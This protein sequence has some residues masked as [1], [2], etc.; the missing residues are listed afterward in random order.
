[1]HRL[2]GFALF[3]CAGS[4][5]AAAPPEPGI[6][7]AKAAMSRLPL[8]FEENRGQWDPAVRF[9]A[10]SAGAN[11]Q[12][13]AHG[14]VFLVGPSRVEIGLAHASPSPVIEP[15]DRLPAATNYLVGARDQWHPGVANYARVRYQSVYPGIDVV[16]YGNQNQLEYD[17]VLAPG[18]NP[19][20]IRLNFHGDVQVSLT[21][22]GDLALTSHGAQV[23]QKAPVIYQDSRRI[24][25]RYT[26]LARNQVGF[27]LDRYHRDRP[28]IIDPIL[29]YCTYMGSS[30]ADR[31]TAIKMG[32]KGQLYITGSTNTGEMQFINGAFNNFNAGLTD[33]FLAIVDTTANGNFAIT[34]FSY[35]GGANLDTPL[36][37]EVDSNGVAYLGGS[38]TSTDF[39]VRG[40][41]VQTTGAATFVDG[42]VAVIDPSLYGGDSLVYST[43]FGG[44]D[45]DSSVNG[46]A[47]DGAGFI[48]IIGTT[49]A[50][51]LPLT[52]SAYAGTKFGSQDAFLAELDRNSTSMVYSTYMGGESA[53]EGRSIAV[54][55][56]GKVYFAVSTTS[57]QFPL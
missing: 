22:G 24:Q 45:G 49:R 53:D 29:V 6:P 44:T 46:I 35:L 26:L 36:A 11:L 32:P 50:T 18:A 9:T 7:Q 15:L 21:P 48:Y 39:P 1:M 41:S 34:Y 2:F 17:F 38:T 40:N 8:R 30:G 19:D 54:G 5:F 33:I 10:R 31:I 23:L 4:L 51:D 16:Y 12:L 27:R 55:T 13:T 57:S 42:F 52:T 56:N 20:A 14:P 43:Y 3:A 47:L 37:L 28:L 25:G